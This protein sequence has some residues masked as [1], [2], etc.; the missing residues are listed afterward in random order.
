MEVIEMKNRNQPPYRVR[1]WC[2]GVIPG[3]WEYNPKIMRH[4]KFGWV[5]PNNDGTSFDHI[6]IETMEK[7]DRTLMRY[8][9]MTS[10]EIETLRRKYEEENTRL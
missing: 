6:D 7:W 10:D 1:Y 3:T 5:V 9:K 2:E 8:V 4:K